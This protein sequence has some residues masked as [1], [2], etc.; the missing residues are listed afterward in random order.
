MPMIALPGAVGVANLTQSTLVGIGALW[1]VPLALGAPLFSRDIYSYIAQGTLLHLGDVPDQACSFRN[2]YLAA[3]FYGLRRLQYDLIT[4]FGVANV[5]CILQL[6]LKIH[7]R[8]SEAQPLQTV[9][10]NHHLSPRG[11]MG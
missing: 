4:D 9:S 5:Q 10:R 3:L 6:S 7:A 2:Y 8:K 1:C 11:G